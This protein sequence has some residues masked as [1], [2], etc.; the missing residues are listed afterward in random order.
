MNA[1]GDCRVEI[2]IRAKGKERVCLEVVPRDEVCIIPPPS[3]L[4][5]TIT[6]TMLR[7]NVLGSPC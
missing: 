2:R 4:L 3:F 7:V 1:G 5:D 6:S